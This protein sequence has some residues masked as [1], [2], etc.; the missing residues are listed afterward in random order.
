MSQIIADYEEEN[1][2]LARELRSMDVA[3]AALKVAH[4]APDRAVDILSRLNSAA[5]LDILW[6]M[7]DVQRELL[8]EIAPRNLAEQWLLDR[9][10][11]TD[12]VGSLMEVPVAVF[13]PDMNVGE[14]VDVLRDLVQKHIVN[15]GFLTDENGK[16]LGVFAFRELLFADK[17]QKLE[18]ISVLKPFFLQ[19]TTK[20]EDAMEDV[21]TRHFPAYPVCNDEGKLV[22]IVRGHVLFEAQAFEISAQAGRMQGVDKEERLTTP[23]KRS[24]K[25]RH[26]WLQLNLLTA[27]IAAAVVGVFQNTLDQIIVLA[28][29]LPVLAGQSG[30][31]GCQALAVTLRG[32]T[33]G[34]LKTFPVF[35]LVSKEA[36]LG[37]SNGAVVG[38]IAGAGMFFYANGQPEPQA[39]FM[40]AVIVWVAMT[41]ACMISGVCGAL[42]P[43]ILKRVGADPA[44]AS[45]IFL[46]TMTD[47]V[48]MGVFLGLASVLVL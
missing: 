24:L 44:T 1:V 45:S 3:K 28:A 11:A 27:F 9:D 36:L 42:I 30:N 7:T 21:V 26:P 41:V 2:K 12:V 5:A 8:Q 39:S 6:H 17:L 37:L 22:G 23:L 25:L 31:T 10:Y 29:F 13:R 48:S 35:S 46:T 16:L 32:M 4:L 15:Y 38:L 40:L 19:D 33:L 47:V 18:E 14:A 43:L 20:L 34:E